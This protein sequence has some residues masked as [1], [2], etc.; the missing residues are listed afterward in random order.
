MLAVCFIF[1]SRF[2]SVDTPNPLD[3]REQTA[4]E[5]LGKTGCPLNASIPYVL[6]SRPTIRRYRG[7]IQDL[8]AHRALVRA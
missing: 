8:S 5:V 7:S 4:N 2:L 6:C 3:E 1:K